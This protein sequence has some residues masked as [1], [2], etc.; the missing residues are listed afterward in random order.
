MHN[1]YLLDRRTIMFFGGAAKSKGLI[2]D[3]DMQGDTKYRSDHGKS[4]PGGIAWPPELIAARTSAGGDIEVFR[5]LRLQL[6]KR[7]FSLG[8]KSLAF[9]SADHDI[10][11]SFFIANLAL[12]FARSDQSTLLIDANLSL[13]RQHSIFN[14]PN[15][16]GLSELL[17]AAEPVD[18]SP[19][20]SDFRHLSVLAAGAYPANPH[21][22]LASKSFSVLTKR[23]S[24]R[25]DITLIDLPPYT[26][27][28]GPLAATAEAEG[29]VLVTR[30]NL[31]RMSDVTMIEK[32][33]DDLGIQL[34]GSVLLDF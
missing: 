22:L 19:H 15:S 21:E 10:G 32:K 6:M 5:E 27:G 25:F 4:G 29:A 1:A 33:L 13:P 30:R 3:A 20:S 18:C 8:H 11:L 16:F 2:D 12:I 26:T 7:W 17:S 9:L 31:S 24:A 14:A 28:A 23:L 34:V